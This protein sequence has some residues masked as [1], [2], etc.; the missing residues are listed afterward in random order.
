MT[1]AGSVK[2]V[3]GV[4]SVAVARSIEGSLVFGHVRRGHA[5]LGS[6]DDD[7]EAV[8]VSD[9]VG[10]GVSRKGIGVDEGS[11]EYS[12]WKLESKLAL[13]R[14]VLE[15]CYSRVVFIRLY[16][17]VAHHSEDR[18]RRAHSQNSCASSPNFLRS[19]HWA[20]RLGHV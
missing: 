3:R 18:S 11:G 6:R 4:E 10:H 17:P 13:V 1:V 19:W 20:M 15:R 8:G 12:G 9:G 7:M 2:D 14:M 5:G 16:T